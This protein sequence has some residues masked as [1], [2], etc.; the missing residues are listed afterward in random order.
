M[1][2]EVPIGPKHEETTMLEMRSSCER[3]DTAL[4]AS[5]TQ[6]VICSYECT[7]CRPCAVE[8][9]DTCPNCGGVLVARPPRAATPATS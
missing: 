5:S 9:D 2:H 8:L 4:E 6:A 3:C 7:F 1:Q